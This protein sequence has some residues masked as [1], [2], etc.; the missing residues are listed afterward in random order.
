MKK[1]IFTLVFSVLSVGLSLAQ[2]KFRTD[3]NYVAFYNPDTKSWS[4]WEPA[5]H[6]LVFNYNDN[7]D[8][9]HYTA[10]GEVLTYRNLGNKSDDYSNGNHYQ[11]IDALDEYGDIIKIQLFDDPEIGMKIIFKDFMV[12]FS[13]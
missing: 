10:K 12:Q 2:D 3:F 6:T 9:V 1:I 7:K 5:E 13:K 11:I 8:I 4:E